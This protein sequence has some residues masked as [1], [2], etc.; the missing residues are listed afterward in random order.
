MVF[1]AEAITIPA[2]EGRRVAAEVHD[3]IKYFSGCHTNQLA[4]G[5]DSYLIMKASQHTD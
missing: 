5:C 3:D 1:G 4:L 2:P